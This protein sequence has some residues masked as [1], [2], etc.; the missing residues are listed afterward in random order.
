VSAW[1]EE[2]RRVDVLVLTVLRLEFDTVLRVDTGAVPGS[3]WE[4]AHG[5]SRLP[6]AF[7][8]FETNMGRPLRVAVAISAD[9]GATAATNTLL[10][11]VADLK[12]RCLAMCGVC[13]G[14]RGKT[15][16]GDVVAAE[17][18][19]YR[20][21]EKRLP[22]EIQ[23]D[24][25]TYQLRDDWKAALH[26]MD[27]V[28][29]FRDAAWFRARPISTEWRE[30][31]ALVA[32]RDGAAEPW[33]HVDPTLDE[34][35]WASIVASLRRH[36]LLAKAGRE[37]TAAGHHMVEK[38]LFEHTGKLPDPSAAGTFQPFRL[39]VAPL[40]S[41]SQVIED[42]AVWAFISRSMR[43]TLALETEGAALGELAHRQRRYEMDAIVMKG[44]MDFADHGRDDH[45]KEFAARA[46][47]EC[48][49]A[50]LRE[51][52]PTEHAAGFDDLL[53]SGTSSVPTNSPAPSSL[54][55]ARYTVVPWHD[56]GR[57]TIMADL[58]AWADDQKCD[59]SVLLLH[60]AG[61][62]GKTRLAIEWVQRRRNRHD[63]AG[64]L[65][66]GPDGLWLERLCGL[67]STVLVVI[68]YAERR[69]DLVDILE[70]VA[71]F[72]AG[73]GPRRRVRIL[74]LARSDGDWWTDLRRRS[75]AVD[76]LLCDVAPK[77]LA[78][79][80][81]TIAD[82]EAVFREASAVF[83]A[84]RNHVGDPP[85]PPALHDRRFERVLYLHMAALAAVEDTAFNA[86]SLMGVIL[87][88]EER[89]W[90]REA[91][92]RAGVA[93]DMRLARRLVA[94]ATLRGGM[95]TEDKAQE[96]CE[97]L[98]KR[99]RSRDDDA[100]IALLH[101]VY[102]RAGELAYLPGLE[103]DLLGEAMVLRVAKPPNGAG[104][105]AGD[106][107]IDHVFI[108]GDDEGALTTGFVILG[109]ASVDSAPV[110]RPWITRLLYTEI[111]A[112]AVLALRA[113]KVVGQGSAYSALGDLLAEAL[114]LRGTAVI[115]ADLDRE[116][117][118]YPA[119]SLQRVATWRS[120]RLLDSLPGGD[121]AA[122]MS[123]RASWLR[124]QGVDYHATGQHEAAVE[125]TQRAV[126]LSRALTARNPDEFQPLLAASLNNL[127]NSLGELGRCDAA[128]E[129]MTE[130][131]A[132][133]RKLAAQ[134]PDAREPDLARSL[135]NLG[136]ALNARCHH[137]RALEAMRDA[138]GLYTK[139]AA[140]NN[141]F[142]APLAM[143][144]NNLGAELSAL[145]QYRL[146]F[147]ATIR[148][149][150]LYWPLA[151][152]YPDAFQPELARSLHNLGIQLSGLGR[153]DEALKV[154]HKAVNLYRRLATRYPDAFQ[155]DL[156]KSLN[157]L[158]NR[159]SKLAA[160]HEA[161]AVTR[162]AVELYR[163]FTTRNRDAFQADLAKSLNNLA[164]QLSD[165]DQHD[166]ALAATREAVDLY[167]VV[168]A[169]SDASQ[170]RVDPATVGSA[171]PGQRKG[172]AEPTR[173]ADGLRYITMTIRQPDEFQLQLAK[174]LAH[175]GSRLSKRGQRDEALAATR[176]AAAL[177]FNLAILAPERFWPELAN[178]LDHLGNV[179]S[180]Q[181]QHD[182]AL[183]VT[184][185]AVR[186]ARLLVAKKSDAFEADLARRL[187]NL[188]RRRSMV[189]QQIGALDDAREAV[190]LYRKLA[191]TKPEV[192]QRD[193]ARSLNLLG[194][195]LGDLGQ[196]DGALATTSEAV[197][198]YRVLATSDP[199]A[200]QPDLVRSLNH[201]GNLLSSQGQQGAALTA[202]QE[203]VELCRML[204]ARDP[205]R[206]EADLAICLNDLSSRSSGAR[207]QQAALDA[208]SEAAR[209]YRRLSERDPHAFQPDLA[210]SL[211]ILGIRFCDLEQHDAALEAA[212]EAVAIYRKLAR[213]DPQRYRP[214]LAASLNNFGSLLSK[215]GERHAAL[216]AT[217]EAVALRRAL[218][219]RSP[220]P[221]ASLAASLSNLGDQCSD[222][223]DSAKAVAASFE[224]VEL[225]RKLATRNPDG[226]QSDLAR[227]LHSLGLHLTAIEQHDEAF[228]A[229]EEA[230]ELCSDLAT[231]PV[232]HKML[233]PSLSPNIHSSDTEQ[234]SASCATL[235]IARMSPT[236]PMRVDE[237]ALAML[238]RLAGAE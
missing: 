53:V 156:A 117:I 185:E 51:Q 24:V 220:D 234:K 203:A 62:V 7:R 151:K 1:S 105:A 172:L 173:Q 10:P 134:N 169:R 223:G 32:M 218:A 71:A 233:A 200:F 80:A 129:A 177:H 26:G 146:A 82:R 145:G 212:Q 14:R 109:R 199:A 36:G 39:H 135:N 162:Q 91:K 70:R 22:G 48:L 49:F 11:L 3:A 163:T 46:S 23:Q 178:S 6:V 188:S 108:L 190:N 104:T 122:A 98:E 161:L 72:A 230:R 191:E 137:D 74:L 85:P 222:L 107:W 194:S 68:D 181:Q 149:W 187:I 83:A 121:D 131:V 12:P 94:A 92:D 60:A 106:A 73:R 196:Q 27:V 144:L 33:R 157:N 69:P 193:L 238:R 225:Y 168:V 52:I 34:T 143:S 176:E 130:A 213:R 17:R 43:R 141:A 217:V 165:L 30:Y 154:T 198:L 174:S 77:K 65:V 9:R 44:V 112:R 231:G 160:R 86:S 87:D 79:L 25:T 124:Q 183:A 142:H 166:E 61:G 180:N 67:G 207:E 132:L 171:R 35:G 102:A 128:L 13:A 119:I 101:D 103:P 159:W 147:E 59:V 140:G 97:R 126:N 170:P 45:F 221:S 175:L 228:A 29:R 38:V 211:N 111:S 40:A 179:L 123:E 50:F 235:Q 136:A 115:A 100:M 150:R 197:A 127:G 84:L 164:D 184:L 76:A 215:L 189:R 20:D 186:L 205:D 56:R 55:L 226:F 139:L 116:G 21:A 236:L 66:P 113:A 16:L 95:H 28:T 120:R 64:F 201:L 214:G 133:Y 204:V 99:P 155:A 37:L 19:F 208:A 2:T 138:V 8:A 110:V 58:D 229:F 209:L 152:W 206:F 195:R 192:F 158:G 89:F 4:V 232:V 167:R 216:T 78:P 88:H 90:V 125:A 114:E 42:E 47:A 18:L 219:A 96:M 93:L 31:R 15:Q 202:T 75:S 54:L 148:A 153:H 210:S 237:A 57:F 224:A 118:P 81:M 227:N 63:I 41:G 5:P 182:A